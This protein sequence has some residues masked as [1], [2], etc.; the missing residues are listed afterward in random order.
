M[1][2]IRAEEAVLK[3]KSGQTVIVSGMG[4]ILMPDE[5]LAALEKRFLETGEPRDLTLVYNVIPGAQRQGTGID[6]FAHPGM[7][8]RIYAGSYYTLEVD[9]INELIQNNEVEAYLVPFG[10]LYN[11]VR[12]AAAGQPGVLTPVGLGTFADPRVGGYKLTPRTTEDIVRVMEIDDKE[13]L[14]YQALPIDVAIIRATTADEDGNLS[15][16]QEP[17]TIGVLHKAMSAKNRGG[18]VIAQVKQN[19]KRGSIHPKSVT[20]PGIFVDYV[21]HAPDQMDAMPYNPAWT[22]DI[23]IPIDSFEPA[24]FDYKKV[25]ARRAAMELEPGDLVNF[26]FGIGATVPR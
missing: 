26:G 11:M 4:E 5:L 18:I 8:K 17:I 22:G 16:E 6:R 20:V 2:N 15:L 10:A 3:I 14:Y 21:V 19:A 12:T 25:I 1:H 7:V 24:P 23:R 9:K 13:Y